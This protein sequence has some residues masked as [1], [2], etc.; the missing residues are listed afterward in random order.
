M[1]NARPSKT[2]PERVTSPEQLNDSIRV[3]HPGV[4]I[5][6]GLIVALLVGAIAW[7]VFGEIDGVHPIWFILH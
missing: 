1:K 5:A 4:W 2:R 7:A 6:L 3:A